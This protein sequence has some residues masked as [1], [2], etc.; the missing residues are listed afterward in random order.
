VLICELNGSFM[1]I[2]SVYPKMQYRKLQPLILDRVHG[3]R[4]LLVVA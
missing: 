2:L 1:F 4:F 3:F